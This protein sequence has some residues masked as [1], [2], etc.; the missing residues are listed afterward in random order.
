[1]KKSLIILLLTSQFVF[2][3]NFEGIVKDITTNEPIEMVSVFVENT[4]TGTVSNQDGQFRISVTNPTQTVKFTHLNYKPFTLKADDSGKFSEVLLE[5]NSFALDEVV[6]LNRPIPDILK[7]LIANS[8]RKAEKG[9]IIDTYYREFVTVNNKPTTF[10][11]G[12]VQYHI[13]SKKGSA[14]TYV[15][16]S[17]VIDTR[18]VASDEMESLSSGYNIRKAISDAYDVDLAKRLMN[19]KYYDYVVRKVGAENQNLIR[20]DFKPIE[21]IEAP[22]F[23]GSITYDAD[24]ELILEIDI[25]SAKR[26]DKYAM[27]FKVFGIRITLNNLAQKTNF[28]IEGDKYIVVYSQKN[29]KFTISETNNKNGTF[30]F[31]SDLV[32]LKYSEGDFSRDKSERYGK[33]NLFSA[34][35]NYSNEFWNG[36]NTRIMTLDE[37]RKV[38]NIK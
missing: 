6:V 24:K 38:N 15:D 20:I 26:F 34:G 32:T 9:V 28:R 30:E 29:I 4:G 14:D 12:L 25:Q 37:E 23:E 21:N 10:S 11:D 7:S 22:L 3:Q 19:S 8:K 31:L 18:D 13:K 27:S 33:N 35:N 36:P 5:P 1:M 2:S 16:Q 17:R